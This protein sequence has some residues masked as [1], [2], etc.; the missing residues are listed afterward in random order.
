V[1]WLKDGVFFVKFNIKFEGFKITMNSQ[2]SSNK[3]TS[4]DTRLE[5]QSGIVVSGPPEGN[6]GGAGSVYHSEAGSVS[7]FLFGELEQNDSRS[8]NR[9]NFERPTEGGA[10]SSLAV[11]TQSNEA[12][13]RGRR[14][15]GRPRRRRDGENV[16][17]V[18]ARLE[19]ADSLKP[20]SKG[21]FVVQADDKRGKQGEGGWTSC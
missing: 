9:D 11:P 17:H 10:E 16:D 15:V 8:A 13:V 7:T 5:S 1:S 18:A 14:N 12:I 6:Q 3:F 2:N 19:H 20:T 4:R 21:L